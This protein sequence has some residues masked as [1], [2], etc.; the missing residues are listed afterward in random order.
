MCTWE[1]AKFPI[2]IKFFSLQNQTHVIAD[3]EK[4]KYRKNLNVL[5]LVIFN[6]FHSKPTKNATEP[7]YVRISIGKSHSVPSKFIE[8]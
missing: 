4:E 7:H 8:H 3:I 5:E 1:K 2:R 6:R